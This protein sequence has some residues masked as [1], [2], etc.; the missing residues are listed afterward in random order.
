MH[1]EEI[2]NDQDVSGNGAG[3][4]DDCAEMGVIQAARVVRLV[5]SVVFA[6]LRKVMQGLCD[7]GRCGP[8]GDVWCVIDDG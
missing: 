4:S 3:A 5:W 2:G 1:E 8:A 6:G 7:R